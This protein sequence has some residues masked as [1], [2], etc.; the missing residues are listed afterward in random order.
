MKRPKFE[1]KPSRKRLTQLATKWHCFTESRKSKISRETLRSSK[2]RKTSQN[3]SFTIC[4]SGREPQNK[5]NDPWLQYQSNVIIALPNR[6]TKALRGVLVK[7]VVDL[8][9]TTIYL[10]KLMCC[11]MRSGVGSARTGK[12]FRWFVWLRK[13]FSRW[14]QCFKIRKLWAR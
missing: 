7:K 4:N 12:E 13:S 11:T 6:S 5:T 3:P 14:A 2:W 9:K 8:K 1:D 10:K